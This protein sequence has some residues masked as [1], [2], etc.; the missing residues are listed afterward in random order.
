MKLSGKRNKDCYVYLEDGVI[1]EEDKNDNDLKI[2]DTDDSR[3]S[4]TNSN[5]QN[6]D[7]YD[8][9]SKH[10]SSMPSKKT[11]NKI[12]VGSITIISVLLIINIF[13]LLKAIKQDS[14]NEF[15]FTI[16]NLNNNKET[17]EELFFLA[18][19]IYNSNCNLKDYYDSLY[20]EI[21]NYNNHSFNKK[22]LDIQKNIQQDL[23]DVNRLD[24]FVSKKTFDSP[25]EIVNNR[26][27]NIYELTE[28][29]LN[30]SNSQ[31]INLY[32]SY[33]N[34]EISLQKKLTTTLSAY[35]EYLKIEHK[36]T[37]DNTII[38]NK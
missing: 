2:M 29:L 17:K 10:I 8:Q 12:L 22:I 34:N 13:G 11:F 25:I 4:L 24:E 9:I 1:I 31:L 6:N 5:S 14:S 7:F 37:N 38:Y 16:N 30:S 32:N 19:V 35:F 21:T 28:K 15:N 36:I 26:F 23:N 18:D 33:A 3:D 27:T 20:K